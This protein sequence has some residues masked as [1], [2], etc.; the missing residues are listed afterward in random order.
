MRAVVNRRKGAIEAN[1]IPGLLFHLTHCRGNK[2]FTGL[3]LPLRD[4]PVIIF[5]AVHEKNLQFPVFFTPDERACRENRGLFACHGVTLLETTA[6][7]LPKCSTPLPRA[8]HEGSPVDFL[9]A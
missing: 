7:G 2:R 9:E 1:P 4:R 3:E 6:Q 5:G 8:F